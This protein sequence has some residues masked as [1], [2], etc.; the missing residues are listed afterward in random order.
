MIYQVRGDTPLAVIS[1]SRQTE[2]VVKLVH[3]WVGFEK[4][5]WM[6]P[7]VQEDHDSCETFMKAFAIFLDCLCRH[8]VSPDKNIDS[9]SNRLA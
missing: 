4:G 6:A 9:M 2:H 5:R 3:F 8:V 7:R 1:V